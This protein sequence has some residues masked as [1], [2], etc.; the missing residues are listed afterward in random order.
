[1]KRLQSS[2]ENPL[3]GCMVVSLRCTSLGKRISKAFAMQNA[4]VVPPTKRKHEAQQQ[5]PAFGVLVMAS[6]A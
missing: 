6:S 4:M 1:M 5:D 3:L 2:E